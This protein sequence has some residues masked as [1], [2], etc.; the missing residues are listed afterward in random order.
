MSALRQEE[1]LIKASTPAAW[2]TVVERW[3]AETQALILS[4][5]IYPPG[6][7]IDRSYVQ[8]HY[9]TIRLQLLRAA[10]RLAAVL[11]RTL[12]HTP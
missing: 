6:K 7:T 1:P 3:H 5:H 8:T 10:V 2:R 12:N 11:Q 4:H 9:Q